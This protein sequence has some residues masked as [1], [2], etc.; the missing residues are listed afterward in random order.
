MKLNINFME[1]EVSYFGGILKHAATKTANTEKH[2]DTL[3]FKLLH[4]RE[5][6]F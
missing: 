6:L 4:I 2:P 1:P 5:K 3:D